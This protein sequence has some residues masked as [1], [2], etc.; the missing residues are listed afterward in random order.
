MKAQFFLIFFSRMN[1]SVET[2]MAMMDSICEDTHIAIYYYLLFGVH[3]LGITF[4]LLEQK[5]SLEDGKEGGDEWSHQGCRLP[6][7]TAIKEG[8]LFLSRRWGWEKRRQSWSTSLTT[9]TTVRIPWS[10]FLIPLWLDVGTPVSWPHLYSL[11]LSSLFSSL[12][13]SWRHTEKVNNYSSLMK[14]S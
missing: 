8:S 13:L 4:A 6:L 5:V 3:W 11:I 9:Q 7:K 1:S 2:M 12:F 10:L 14:N